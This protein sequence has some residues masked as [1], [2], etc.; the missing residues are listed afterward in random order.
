MKAGKR[1]IL[2]EPKIVKPDAAAEYLTPEGCFILETWNTGADECVSVA[3]ARVATGRA[4]AWHRLDGIV[5][6]YLIVE[7]RGLVEVG[8][9]EP[10]ELRPG[11][12]AV[13]PAGTRQRI[14]NT[15][16]ADLVFYCICTPRFRP[17][18]YQVCD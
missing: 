17:E 1:E 9:L 10:A 3:R 11:D 14:T 18:R 16:P 6:R 2:M 12:M 4:T 13:I 15:G 7:G 5:E 8:D